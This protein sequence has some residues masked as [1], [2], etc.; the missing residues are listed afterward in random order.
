MKSAR[1]NGGSRSGKHGGGDGRTVQGQGRGT[2]DPT[3]RKLG[4]QRPLVNR[5]P[6]WLR[7]A[8]RGG[9]LLSPVRAGLKGSLLALVGSGL[10]GCRDASTRSCFPLSEEVGA[11]WSG[12]TR[13]AVDC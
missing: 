7:A 11:C 10:R 12:N 6:A 3:R 4:L 5:A 2:G 1:L 8:K 13:G 9:T